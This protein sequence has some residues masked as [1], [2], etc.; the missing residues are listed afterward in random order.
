MVHVDVSE[1]AVAQHSHELRVVR[2]AF[3]LYRLVP[4]KAIIN[5]MR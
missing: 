3:H 1:L 5:E 4:E 2:Q